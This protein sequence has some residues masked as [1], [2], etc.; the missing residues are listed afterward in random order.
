MRFAQMSVRPVD[1]DAARILGL[2]TF[3]RKQRGQIFSLAPN[4]LKWLQRGVRRNI[5]IYK[6]RQIKPVIITCGHR[7]AVAS[8]MSQNVNLDIGDA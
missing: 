5:L 7:M 4:S 6:I 3:D 1:S 8:A 2:P